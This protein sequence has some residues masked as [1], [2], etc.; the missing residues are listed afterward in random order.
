MDCDVVVIGAGLAGLECARV[1]ARA[2][3]RRARA[4]GG[5]RRRADGSGPTTSTGYTLD[6]GFQVL[7]PAYPAVRGPRR[8]RPPRPAALPARRRGPARPGAGA[9][10]RPATRAVRRCRAPCAAATCGPAE[11]LALARWAGRAGPLGPRSGACGTGP[12][13][14]ARGVARRAGV[15]GRIR[16][17]VLEPFLAGVL[18][19]DRRDD[20]GGVRPAAGPLVPARHPGRPG[21]GQRGA[22]RAARPARPHGSTSACGPSGSRPSPAATGS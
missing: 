6:R 17:E 5:R 20:V 7:N 2:R 12:G 22:A 19:E 3:G 10:R 15:D 11:L 14:D 8:P 16:R 13:H 18:G 1:A 21:G 4:R 9:P